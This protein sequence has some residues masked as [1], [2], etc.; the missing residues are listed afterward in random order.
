MEVLLDSSFVISCIK[1]KI[2]FLDE[3]EKLGF[4][5]LL[6]REVLQE[7]KDLKN[8]SYHP[9]RVAIDVALELFEKRKVKKITLG[10]KPVDLG[11]IEMGKKG[12]YIATLD[13]A[14][15]RSV[16][17]KVIISEQKNNVVVERR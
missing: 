4:K 1:K 3:L 17:N 13:N 2:D 11:L 7:L 8:E 10:K 6:P 12:V 9:D 15:R 5:V 14:I 16:P